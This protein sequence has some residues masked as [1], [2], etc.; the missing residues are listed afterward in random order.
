MKLDCKIIEDLL[1]TYLD[2]MCSEQTREAVEEHLAECEDCHSIV[3][4]TKSIQIPHIQLEKP[5]VDKVVKKGFK[6][7][8][9]RWWA[10]IVAI[11]ILIPVIY[12]GWNQYQGSG[13]SFTNIY[14]IYTGNAFM[15]CIEKGDYE[16]AYKYID[17]DGIKQEWLN[18]GT[19]DEEMLENIK[20]DGLAKFS[21]YGMKLEENGGILGYKYVGISLDSEKD[22]GTPVYQMIFKIDCGDY[23]RFIGVTVSN[24]GIDHILVSDDNGKPLAQFA[25]W[26]YY[27]WQEYE[28]KLTR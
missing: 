8:R 3:E 24:D 26:S 12:L 5:A 4:E 16:K 28:E 1:P 25:N 23:K 18:D 11:L 21:E 19:F 9:F 14:E 20:S 7:I 13:V 17:V 10:S 6:K 15:K 27:L 2:D 22:D